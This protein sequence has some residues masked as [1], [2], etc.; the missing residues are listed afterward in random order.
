MSDLN[1]TAGKMMDKSSQASRGPAN[2]NIAHGAKPAPGQGGL[3]KSGGITAPL[4]GPD[5]G[6]G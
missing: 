4:T 5:K 1:K 3:P 6:R 2:K